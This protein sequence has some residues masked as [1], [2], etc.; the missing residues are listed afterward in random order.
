MTAM[1]GLKR[2]QGVE[3]VEAYLME[4]DPRLRESDATRLCFSAVLAV[5]FRRMRSK[6]SGTPGHDL[7]VLVPI[8]SR[9]YHLSILFP[10]S[11]AY[12]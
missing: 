7:P 8:K 4:D 1:T 10:I 5:W 2:N 9:K 11:R 6:S 3:T 12:I